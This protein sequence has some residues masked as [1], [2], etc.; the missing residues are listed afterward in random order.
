[1]E[2]DLRSAS[3][4]ALA[5]LDDRVKTIIR[6]AAQLEEVQV[7]IR[8]VGERPAAQVP[9]SAPIVRT[10]MESTEATGERA[11]LRSGSTD[12]NYPMSLGIPAIT[13]GGGGSASGAHSPAEK[14][15]TTNSYKGTQRALL[16]T[17][18]LAGGLQ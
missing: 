12:A 16:V 13:L 1:M 11:S 18:A 7:D 6:Q 5:E 2:I 14:F 17:V 15:D 3:A 8:E 4:T 9:A 10:A